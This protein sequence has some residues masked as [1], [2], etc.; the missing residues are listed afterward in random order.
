MPSI[1]VSLIRG[2]SET[3]RR[4]L[5]RRLTDAT[6]GALGAKP[7]AVT[8]FLNEVDPAGYSR[9]GEGRAPGV[10]EER[11]PDEIVRDFLAAMEARDL[12]AARA[13]LAPDFVMS[14]PGT[15]E[16]TD[17]AELVA[18]S[19]GRYRFVR[20]RFAGFD[21]A[22]HA[23]RTVVVCRG[24]LAG[25]WPDGTPFDGVRFIDRFEIRAGKLARQ[26]VWNDL[27]VAAR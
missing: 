16:M 13:H 5:C 22:D 4:R 1:Q 26:E 2:Y 6:T 17:L 14:F 23:D 11:A 25:E 20:K 18:W 7:E 27:A 15:G 9:G 10:A 8:V 3:V 12:D 19:A 24:T 21:V